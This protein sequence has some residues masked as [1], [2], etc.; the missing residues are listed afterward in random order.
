MCNG[1]G[2]RR[3]R[4]GLVLRPCLADSGEGL[5]ASCDHFEDQLAPGIVFADLPSVAV[6]IIIVWIIVDHDA[7]VGVPVSI[8][9]VMP[10]GTGLGRSGHRDDCGNDCGGSEEKRLHYLDLSV[11]VSGV[12]SNGCLPSSDTL[13]PGCRIHRCS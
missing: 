7:L 11:R 13:F 10:S 6:I 12:V 1:L 5:F 4:P 8:A 2:E 9:I 3:K